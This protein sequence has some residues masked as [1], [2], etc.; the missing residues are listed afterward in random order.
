MKHNYISPSLVA[1]EKLRNLLKTRGWTYESFAF[2]F[3]VDAR[4]VGRWIN[5]GISKID[6]IYQIAEHFEVDAK[7]LLL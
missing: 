3:G 7:S 4:Q 1:G 5:N 2:D 6:I